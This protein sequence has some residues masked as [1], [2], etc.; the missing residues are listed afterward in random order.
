MNQDNQH[1][2]LLSI[3]HYIVGGITALFSLLPIFH[4]ILGLVM[5]L[6]PEKLGSK[7]QPPPTFIGWLFVVLAVIVITVGW[8][9]SAFII[10]AGRFL[11]KRKHY[12]FCLIMAGIESILTPFGTV[13]GVFTIIVLMRE[14][15]KQLFSANHTPEPI[16]ANRAEASA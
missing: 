2:R 5:I 10:T 4:L 3:F 13:L 15:V 14:S 9:L 12:L 16:V 7:G 11:A 6:A 8:T 1:L